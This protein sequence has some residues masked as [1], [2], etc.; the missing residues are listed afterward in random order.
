MAKEKDTTFESN[1]S[2]LNDEYKPSEG[3]TMDRQFTG[4]FNQKF[5][6]RF[7]KNTEAIV[8]QQVL[9]VEDVDDVSGTS[10]RIVGDGVFYNSHFD[11]TILEMGVSWNALP[12]ANI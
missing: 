11:Y 9:T 10:Y 12:S 4:Q 3:D 6:W 2:T 1:S 8:H 5:D 7:L